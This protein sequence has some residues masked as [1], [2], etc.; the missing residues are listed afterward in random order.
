MG[1]D[2]IPDIKVFFKRTIRT[3]FDFGNGLDYVY[4]PLKTKDGIHFDIHVHYD[5]RALTVSP[6][7]IYQPDSPSRINDDAYPLPRDVQTQARDHMNSVNNAQWE[8]FHKDGLNDIIQAESKGRFRAQRP[9]ASGTG[10]E[11]FS[12]PLVN[13]IANVGQDNIMGLPPGTIGELR[14]RLLT[15]G[16][17]MNFRTYLG[18]MKTHGEIVS[19]TGEGMEARFYGPNGQLIPIPKSVVAGLRPEDILQIPEFRHRVEGENVN[20]VF[21][22][23]IEIQFVLLLS[24]FYLISCLWFGCC[25]GCA[26]F[27]CYLGYIHKGKMES[28]AFDGDCL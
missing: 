11:I 15:E 18:E 17:Q 14:S 2:A 5:P 28:K 19:R 9:Y 16:N 7:H 4:G 1:I 13:V 26:L 3:R 20:P 6:A 22:P 23:S 25:G 24:I 8:T 12:F 27:G 10:T 21:A